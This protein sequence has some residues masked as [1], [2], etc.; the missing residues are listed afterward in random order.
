[1][2]KPTLE[3]ILVPTRVGML[4]ILCAQDKE[5]ETCPHTRGDDPQL[6]RRERY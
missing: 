1:M 2:G 5:V 6:F 4:L 3:I